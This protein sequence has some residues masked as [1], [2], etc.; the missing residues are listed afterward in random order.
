MD[1]VTAAFN[2]LAAFNQF[3]ATPAGQ[4]FATDF[5]QVVGDI[6]GALGVHLVSN[7]PGASVAAVSTAA[8]LIGSVVTP[9]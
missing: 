2:A 1:P 6:L 7:V 4:V 9:K 3:L 5:Q 8:K